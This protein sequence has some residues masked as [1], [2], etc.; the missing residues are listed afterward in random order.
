MIGRHGDICDI[1]LEHPSVSR[2][3]ALVY[4]DADGLAFI[5]DN[6]STHGTRVNIQNLKA[7]ERQHLRVGDVIQFGASTRLHILCG[8]EELR[9]PEK[10][11][12]QAPRAGSLHARGR[13]RFEGSV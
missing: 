5:T 1:V 6:G 7:G 9:P 4:F 11:R 13:E 10:E 12:R 2:F 3:H 8:P